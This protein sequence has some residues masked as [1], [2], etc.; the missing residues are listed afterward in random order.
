MK[1]SI[2]TASLLSLSCDIQK[3]LH[4]N[5]FLPANFKTSHSY[6]HPFTSTSLS[7]ISDK[8]E[9]ST[10]S[11]IGIGGQAPRP[12]IQIDKNIHHNI[13]EEEYQSDKY[14][15]YELECEEEVQSGSIHG[16]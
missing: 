9:S 11:I 15:Q 2:A 13:G 14:H 3:V 4:V 8:K 6:S 7:A 12:S 1:L 10:S 16:T 5:A